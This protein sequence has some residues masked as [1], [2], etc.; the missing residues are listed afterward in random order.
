V[1]AVEALLGAPGDLERQV[2]GLAG[3]CSASVL[4]SEG[5]RR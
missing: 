2:V 1:Q 5:A 4:P 3:Q